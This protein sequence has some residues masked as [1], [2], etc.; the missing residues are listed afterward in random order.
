[1]SSIISLLAM[2]IF[3]S[4]SQGVSILL[5]ASKINNILVSVGLFS[6]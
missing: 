1:M 4:L 5:E 6:S 2:L 3:V